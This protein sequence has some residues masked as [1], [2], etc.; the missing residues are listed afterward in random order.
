MTKV[1]LAVPL[2]TSFT[3]QLSVT[4]GFVIA[5]P[6]NLVFPFEF[7]KTYKPLKRIQGPGTYSLGF[8]G[9]RA[10]VAVAWL[11]CRATNPGVLTNGIESNNWGF[12]SK[13]VGASSGG[14]SK[15]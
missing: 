12:N 4:S 14:N 2:A 11:A 15:A 5:F 9:R 1:Y 8:L 10:D 3:S 7:P 13:A 6:D